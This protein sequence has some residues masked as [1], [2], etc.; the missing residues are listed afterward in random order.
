MFAFD[1]LADFFAMGR[2]GLYVW[3][4]YGFAAAVVIYNQLS[5]Y[6]MQRRMVADHRRRQRREQGTQPASS[7]GVTPS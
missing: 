6:L 4:A 2:H 3:T 7:S 5:P 1:S